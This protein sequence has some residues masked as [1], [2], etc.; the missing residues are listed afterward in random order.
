MR[1]D[2]EDGRGRWKR[3]AYKELETNDGERDWKGDE[4]KKMGKG[5]KEERMGE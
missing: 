4:G 2:A 1:W 3:K 5:E